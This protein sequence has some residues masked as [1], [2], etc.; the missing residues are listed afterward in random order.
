MNTAREGGKKIKRL[1]GDTTTTQ[2][3]CTKWKQRQKNCNSYKYETLFHENAIP[4]DKELQK[5]L[6]VTPPQPHETRNR[7]TQKEEKKINVCKIKLLSFLPFYF[8]APKTRKSTFSTSELSV[9]PKKKKREE[10][11]MNKGIKKALIL[12]FFA[13]TRPN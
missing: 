8:Y 6:P 9:A 3:R 1:N 2:G 4:L 10:K 5:E 7:R 12:W 13:E 11:S